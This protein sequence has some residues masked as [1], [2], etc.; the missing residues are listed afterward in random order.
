[1]RP[2]PE[3]KLKNVQI[4][5]VSTS[6]ALLENKSLKQIIQNVFENLTGYDDNAL[7]KFAESNSKMCRDIMTNA[8]YIKMLKN[9]KFDVGICSEVD[10]CSLALFKLLK[11]EA[12]ILTTPMPFSDLYENIFGIP[13]HRSYSTSLF[14]AFHNAP[15]LNFWERF[16]HVWS[17][18]EDIFEGNFIMDE[19]QKML[20]KLFGKN[21]FNLYELFQN[22]DIMVTNGHELIDISRPTT[23]KI[24]KI[25]GLAMKKPKNLNLVSF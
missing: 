1:M 10:P 23:H 24:V 16:Q 11:I 17:D 2:I 7:K 12:V 8:D 6:V 15:N 19:N 21:V 25:G 13:I 14:S 9:E 22:V 3:I 20:D 5:K 4:S 18:L